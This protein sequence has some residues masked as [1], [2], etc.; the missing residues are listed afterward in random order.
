MDS[1]SGVGGNKV[2]NMIGLYAEI[3]DFDTPFFSNFFDNL[4]KPLFN[5]TDENG[6]AS[7]RIPD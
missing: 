3:K 5:F 4:F 7:F 6:L 2:V 1:N